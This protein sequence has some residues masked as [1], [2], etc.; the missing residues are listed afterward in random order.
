MSIS[1]IKIRETELLPC[2]FCA[3]P[4]VTML[5]DI[6]T[7]RAFNLSELS[8]CLPDNDSD[9]EFYIE[10]LVFCHECG[11]ES[12]SIDGAVYFKSCAAELINQAREKWNNRDKRHYSLFESSQ[13][14]NEENYLD[15]YFEEGK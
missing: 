6:K 12:E 8:L 15:R 1:P 13:P 11:A 14:V 9:K 2:P 3:G 7:D 4:P 10:A 5:R